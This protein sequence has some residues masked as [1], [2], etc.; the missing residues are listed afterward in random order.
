M[1]ADY[2]NVTASIDGVAWSPSYQYTPENSGLRSSTRP[3]VDSLAESC[4][5]ITEVRGKN[6]KLTFGPAAKQLGYEWFGV[7]EVGFRCA[8]NDPA[9]PTTVPTAVPTA[10]PTVEPT[11]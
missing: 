3:A 10:V 11:S 8:V 6:V 9:A 4:F 7:M 1:G 5:N 2:V